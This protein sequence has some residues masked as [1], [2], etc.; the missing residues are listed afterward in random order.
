MSSDPNL[1][2]LA[3]AVLGKNGARARDTAWD[4]R[5]TVGKT[6][7]HSTDDAGT[8][9]TTLDH[10]DNPTVPL[11]QALGDGTLGHPEKHGT[12][13]GTVAGQRYGDVLDKLRLKCPDPVSAE[14]R[15]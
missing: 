3:Y 6:L 5:G 15:E 1:L 13:R 4:S 11:S 8:A 10:S 7:S 2:A 9:K 14:R 12:P